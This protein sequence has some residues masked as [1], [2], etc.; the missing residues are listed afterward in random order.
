VAYDKTLNYQDGNDI[1][2]AKEKEKWKGKQK[3]RKE[4]VI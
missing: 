4:K 3:Q 1:F 2:S